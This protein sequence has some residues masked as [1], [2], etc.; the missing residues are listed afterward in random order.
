MSGTQEGKKRGQNGGG[1]PPVDS[2]TAAKVRR[3][4]RS[5]LS[6]AEV[7]RRCEV[8]RSTV[9]RICAAA[10]PPI[11]FD[12]SHTSAA[13][14]AHATDLKAQRQALAEDVLVQARG[15][16]AKFTAPHVKVGWYQGMGSEHYLDGPESGDVKNYAIALGILLDKH[17]V[18]VKH[19]SEGVDL[20]GLDAFLAHLIPGMR[21]PGDEV[22]A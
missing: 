8:S 12:R 15:I 22:A 9:A 1:R 13:V 6:Q 18:L 20:Q 4:A 14:Q 2:K 16:M 5:G 10:K 19:D 7:A 17:L 11:S 3:L 21:L